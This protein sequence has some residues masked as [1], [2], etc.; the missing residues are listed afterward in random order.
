MAGAARA[1]WA[2]NEASRSFVQPPCTTHSADL[3]H[4][5]SLSLSLSLGHTRQRRM[6]PHG[7]AELP[8]Q[9]VLTR[10]R[11]IC[12][13]VRIC[14]ANKHECRR[15]HCRGG[16][17]RRGCIKSASGINRKSMRAVVRPS[18]WQSFILFTRLDG[19]DAVVYQKQAPAALWLQ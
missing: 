4:R 2:K 1:N 6:A 16:S 11:S 3:R 10:F 12:L 13:S 17:Q 5:T 15:A 8:L 19:N 9:L 7:R 18:A 14:H